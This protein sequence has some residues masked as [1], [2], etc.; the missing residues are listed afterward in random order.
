MS[1]NDVYDK[2]KKCISFIYLKDENGYY[3]IGTGFFVSVKAENEKDTRRHTYLVTAKH[4][5]LS[6][7]RTFEPAIRVRMNKFDGTSAYTLIDTT[8]SPILTHDE[9]G[10]DIAVIKGGPNG[11]FNFISI[12]FEYLSTQ[13]MIH[14]NTIK[15][16]DDVFFSGLFTSH[17]GQKK[18][19]PIFRFGKLALM[20]D[21]K[22]E[23]KEENQSPQF[24]DL[25]LM[26]C[27]SFGGNSGS[28]VFFYLD[29]RVRSNTVNTKQV[30]ILLAGI[31]KGNFNTGTEVENVK[32]KKKQFSY[33]NLG[34]AAVVPAYK[35]VEILSSDEAKKQRIESEKTW[36][37]K[38]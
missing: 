22:I 15:E 17:V 9:Q 2:A 12:P 29:S 10:V 34:I 26:E 21:E 4:V 13:E 28:P 32:S 36:L 20:S 3:P 25:Y 19:Q 7:D 14:E 8:T 27:Q 24:I 11:P 16:G 5:L 33:Q 37:S 30:Q 1:T 31:M 6:D 35:L 18:I 23:W 38:Q